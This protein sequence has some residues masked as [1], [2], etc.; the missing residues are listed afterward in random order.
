MDSRGYMTSYPTVANIA[1]EPAAISREPLA[2]APDESSSAIKLGRFPRVPAGLI[3]LL[4]GGAALALPTML[5]VARESWSTE[6]GAHGPIVLFTGLW[7]L[8]RLWPAAILRASSP[9]GL[10]VA[11]AFAVILPA[12]VLSRITQII[13]LEGYIMYAALIIA[14]WSVI[15]TAAMRA[16]WFP[17]FYL[18]FIFPPPDS[19]VAAVTLPMK[20][21]LS[22][23]AVGILSAF[24]YPI[25]RAGVTIYIG[26]YDLLVAAACSGLNSIFAL[27]ALSL[28]YIYIRHQAEWRY[29]LLL[30]MFIVPVALIANLVRVLI[31]ILLTYHAGEAAAQGFLHNFAGLAMFTAALLAIFALDMV[32]KPLWDRLRT[33]RA[34]TSQ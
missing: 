24:G 4:A 2:T 30:I 32:L 5:Y 3:A 23:F 12:F 25:G 31:L 10:S 17:L 29:A 7:L 1:T 20:M 34:G 14:L 28:F 11:L 21:G 19:L 26:Q 27:S 22:Q 8:A 16:L 18:A 6:Q 13:E 9:R 15:G 33:R